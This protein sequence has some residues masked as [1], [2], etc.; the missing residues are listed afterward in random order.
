MPPRSA[1]KV[2]VAQSLHPHRERRDG[3]RGDGSPAVQEVL[4]TLQA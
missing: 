4:L 1:Q 3:S 2:V